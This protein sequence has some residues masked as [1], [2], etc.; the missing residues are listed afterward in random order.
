MEYSYLVKFGLLIEES[1]NTEERL[2]AKQVVVEGYNNLV[3]FIRLLPEGSDILEVI[4]IGIMENLEDLLKD[5]RE[6]NK[7]EGLETGNLKKES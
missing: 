6:K 2:E 5:F 1:G 3:E 7:P 4:N